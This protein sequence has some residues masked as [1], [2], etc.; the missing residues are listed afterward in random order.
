MVAVPRQVHS[1]YS[2]LFL[3]YR[4]EDMNPKNA[5]MEAIEGLARIEE[6]LSKIYRLFGERFPANRELW[7]RMA[8]EET[9][10]AQWVRDLSSRVEDGSLSLDEDRFGVEGILVFLEYAEDKFQEA[11]AEKLPFLHALDIALD[12]ESSLLERKLYQVFKAESE[13]MEQVLQDMERQIHEHTE[14]I[15][16]ALAHERGQA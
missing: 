15:G 9:N 12:L 4:R 10:H 5:G 7:S 6:T 14:R 2:I 13:S 16:E 11:K 3:V 1:F 8:Q